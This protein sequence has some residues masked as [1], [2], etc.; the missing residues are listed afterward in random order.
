MRAAVGLLDT[1]EDYLFHNRWVYSAENWQEVVEKAAKLV[2]SIKRF[3]GK[4]A[5]RKFNKGLLCYVVKTGENSPPPFVV[6]ATE[7][8][9]QA[10]SLTAISRSSLDNSGEEDDEEQDED[11]DGAFEGSDASGDVDDEDRE[12][13]GD[14]PSDG[15][16]SLV[17]PLPIKPADAPSTTGASVTQHHRPCLVQSDPVWSTLVRSSLT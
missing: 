2:P 11:E 4:A 16:P 6:R 1:L 5:R 3:D 8:K 13:D 14:V 9:E 12:E 17:P 10:D 15:M 7:L